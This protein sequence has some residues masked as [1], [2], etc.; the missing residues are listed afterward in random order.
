MRSA[1]VIGEDAA[2]PRITS[3]AE[4]VKKLV[5][6]TPDVCADPVI[7]SLIKKW[8]QQL[9]VKVS[10]YFLQRMKTKWDSC[11]HA[12]GTSASIRNLLK[13]LKI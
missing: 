9:K 7:P 5:T 1:G 8:E 3:L 13:S 2:S 12:E 10:G 4:L 6:A 11:N